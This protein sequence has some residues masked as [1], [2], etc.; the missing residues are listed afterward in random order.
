MSLSQ[1]TIDI[2]KENESKFSE[3]LQTS[4]QKL[5]SLALQYS[6]LS[7]IKFLMTKGNEEL[8]GIVISTVDT[9]W[10]PIRNVI[11]IVGK[12]ADSSS[13]EMGRVQ[14]IEIHSMFSGCDYFKGTL[15]ITSETGKQ[16]LGEY[17][18]Q[19]SSFPGYDK[20][21]NKFTSFPQNWVNSVITINKITM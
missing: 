20:N 19:W 11:R 3:E 6:P 5:I 8:P 15:T 13:L 10:V 17:K 18:W 4:T 12:I 16:N 9:S 21:Y 14:E 7:D 2:I 1:I